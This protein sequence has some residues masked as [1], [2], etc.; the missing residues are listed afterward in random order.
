MVQR[1]TWDKTSDNRVVSGRNFYN[2]DGLNIIF[3]SVLREVSTN[4]RSDASFKNPDLRQNPY[5]PGSRKI[6]VKSP[7]PLAAPPDSGIVRPAI[8]KVGVIGLF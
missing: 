3:G 1:A 2:R 8:S 4:N 6:T 5:L 7:Y